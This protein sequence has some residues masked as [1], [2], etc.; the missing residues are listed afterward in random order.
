MWATLLSS[1]GRALVV[2]VHD[3]FSVTATNPTPNMT[4][5]STISQTAQNVS[6]VI[7]DM[8]SNTTPKLISEYSNSCDC[9]ITTSVFKSECA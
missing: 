9:R 1:R 2:L 7:S 4:A 6:S 8:A 5:P 3:D